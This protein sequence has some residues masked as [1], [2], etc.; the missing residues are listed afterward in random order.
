M[1]LP[2]EPAQE[3]APAVDEAAYFDLVPAVPMHT[4]AEA[5]PGSASETVVGVE[6][7][8]AA[9]SP[10]P[11]DL[12]PVQASQDV[13]AEPVAE[14]DVPEEER[15][16]APQPQQWADKGGWDS[17]AIYIA[18]PRRGPASLPADER[19]PICT[20]DS[21]AVSRGSVCLGT[22]RHSC[23]RAQRGVNWERGFR[24]VVCRLLGA[25]GGMRAREGQQLDFDFEYHGGFTNMYA[26]RP[27]RI[28]ARAMLF[29]NPSASICAALIIAVPL[30]RKSFQP[31]ATQMKLGNRCGLSCVRS[32][33][34]CAGALFKDAAHLGVQVPSIGE[35]RV[36]HTALKKV[37]N[38]DG[39]LTQTIRLMAKTTL[40]YGQ[41]FKMPRLCLSDFSHHMPRLSKKSF[42][43]K[44]SHSLPYH[45]SRPKARHHDLGRVTVIHLSPEPPS[46]VDICKFF[47][48]TVGG[49]RAG[50]VYVTFRAFP[51]SF[52]PLSA[53]R[54]DCPS[55]RQALP[56]GGLH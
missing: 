48:R 25:L 34:G 49:V 33:K 45:Q 14:A 40:L 9:V 16:E 19:F 8:A 28:R 2:A 39:P 36:Q 46:C 47:A 5:S 3:P 21:V 38:T 29:T 1:R 43:N 51:R 32:V 23:A 53:L 50:H 44:L 18:A 54:G 22:Q 30:G 31:R 42:V 27:P 11:Y 35:V 12:Q 6:E 13:P 7:H 52:V 20:R 26:A 56:A 24:G 41:G 15:A 4:I 10:Y 55:S 17:G 37:G